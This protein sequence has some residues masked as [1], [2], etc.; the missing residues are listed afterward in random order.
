MGSVCLWHS[1]LST[2]TTE[3][4]PLCCERLARPPHPFQMEVTQLSQQGAQD[5]TWVLF[6]SGF[7]SFNSETESMPYEAPRAEAQ[8]Q[9]P[10]RE[11]SLASESFLFILVYYST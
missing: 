6:T 5:S 3:L 2:Y 4:A 7:I 11:V 8:P 9:G 10:E 1:L